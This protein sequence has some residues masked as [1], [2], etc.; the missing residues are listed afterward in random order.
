MK[1]NYQKTALVTGGAKRIGKAIAM[2]LAR[3]GYS[4]IIHYNNSEL[5]AK[6]IQQDIIKIGAN[7][8]IIKANLFNKKEVEE[9]ILQLKNI[10]SW[11]L[12]VNNASIF[13]QSKFLDNNIDDFDKNLTIHLKIPAILSRA[14]ADNCQQNQLSGNIINMIDKNI[15]RFETKYFNYLLSKKFLAEFTKMLSLQLAPNIRVNAIAPGFILNSIDEKK[16][17]IETKKLLAKIPLKKKAD[18]SNIVSGVNYLLDNHFIT[19]EILFIDGGA[20][21]NHAG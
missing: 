9:M 5:E 19:G 3:Q 6:D 20:S 16:P 4:I 1:T 2:N 15:T 14:M 10:K 17:N 21:L 11:N 12:L 13:N 8:Q 18:E 7:C